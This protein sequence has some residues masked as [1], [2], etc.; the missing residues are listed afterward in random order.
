MTEVALMTVEERRRKAFGLAL[1]GVDWNI[2]VQNCGYATRTEAVADVEE[3]LTENPV[4]ALSPG[5]TKALQMA[6][7]SRLLSSVWLS[8]IGGNNRS[9]EVGSSLIRQLMKAQGIEES[10][11]QK[12]PEDPAHKSAYD[13]LAARRPG[14]VGGPR[15]E[16]NGRRRGPHRGRV[17]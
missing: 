13:E 15:R 4:D 2:I 8:A 7:L 10:D 5:A 17:G 6:R 12:I 9:V 14:T 11:P 3:A 16:A 1:A